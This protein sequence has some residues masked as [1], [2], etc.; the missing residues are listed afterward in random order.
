MCLP[1][2]A[3]APDRSQA[4]DAMDLDE[5]A[6]HSKANHTPVSQ[7]PDAPRQ[8][9]EK[10]RRLPFE[11]GEASS[12]YSYSPEDAD[13][14]AAAAGMPMEV[15]M[16]TAVREESLAEE[17]LNINARE[18]AACA[19][20]SS[21]AG[22][23]SIEL[24]ADSKHADW[25]EYN[26][27]RL[28]GR[29]EATRDVSYNELKRQRDAAV[30]TLDKIKADAQRD[31]AALV[32]IFD[33]I[34]SG[35]GDGDVQDRMT[36]VAAVTLHASLL[37]MLSL[38]Q[39]ES[40]VKECSGDAMYAGKT[41]VLTIADGLVWWMPPGGGETVAVKQEAVIGVDNDDAELIISSKGADY[42]F[43]FGLP[44]RLALVAFQQLDKAEQAIQGAIAASDRLY[45]AEAALMAEAEQNRTTALV[46]TEPPPS[47]VSTAPAPAKLTKRV[48]KGLEL[49][50]QLKAIRL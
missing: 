40:S 48:Q 1:A 15:A 14:T 38:G 11:Q 36:Q 37:E 49:R 27:S 31:R 16:E 44:G 5:A 4:T 46:T 41:G 29:H 18:D 45:E 39:L 7:A 23:G 30:E 2:P 26:Q 35:M 22:A 13:A 3:D 47:A 32:G 12:G 20:R 21:R 24:F 9:S 10:R 50:D 43:D 33:Q 8:E 6:A 17:I 34:K 42:H 28:G 19:R 25:S